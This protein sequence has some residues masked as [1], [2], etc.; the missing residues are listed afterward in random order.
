MKYAGQS[1][2]FG[3]SVPFHAQTFRPWGALLRMQVFRALST[4][5]EGF[6]QAAGPPSGSFDPGTFLISSEGM[7]GWPSKGI[8]FYTFS[9]NGP[10]MLCGLKHQEPWSQRSSLTV[11]PEITIESTCTGNNSSNTIWQWLQGMS[12]VSHIWSCRCGSGLRPW[13]SVCENVDLIPGL[14]QGVKDPALLQSMV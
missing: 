2:S 5:T 4:H 14:T 3:A 13:H 8:R 1:F 6:F 10:S 9:S 12:R 11:P 7:N